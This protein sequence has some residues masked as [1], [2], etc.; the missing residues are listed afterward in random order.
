[1]FRRWAVVRTT[2]RSLEVLSRHLTRRGAEHRR[3]YWWV[4]QRAVGNRAPLDVM[5]V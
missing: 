3:H 5:H 4:L 2:D 1:M